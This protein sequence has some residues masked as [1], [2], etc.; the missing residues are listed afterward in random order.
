[1]AHPE[2]VRKIG[3]ALPDVEEGTTYGTPALKIRGQ[4]RE[5]QEQAPRPEGEALVCDD[6]ETGER[7]Q[8]DG[9]SVRLCAQSETAIADA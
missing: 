6:N 9:G 7:H 1:L 3:L 2:T 4:L 5:R 8:P